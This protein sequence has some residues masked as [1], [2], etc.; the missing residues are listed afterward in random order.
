M[1]IEGWVKKEVYQLMKL[2]GY[3]IDYCIGSAREAKKYKFMGGAPWGSKMIWKED[4]WVRFYV[5]QD[6][7]DYLPNIDALTDQIPRKD[8]PLLV[9]INDPEIS[10]SVAKRL[11][12]KY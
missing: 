6:I 10:Q 12:K 9:G 3:E 1:F 7:E 8:L 2:A 11:K 5:D 4:Y